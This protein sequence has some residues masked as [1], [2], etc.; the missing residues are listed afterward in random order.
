MQ[1]ADWP[2]KL[3]KMNPSQQIEENAKKKITHKN[4]D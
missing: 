3:A 2:P 1:C 4:V